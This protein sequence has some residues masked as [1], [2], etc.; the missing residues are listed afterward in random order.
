MK[1][2]VLQHLT[3]LG[4]ALNLLGVTL[5]GTSL[6][7]A[8]GYC[9]QVPRFAICDTGGHATPAECCGDWTGCELALQQLSEGDRSRPVVCVGADA[10]GCAIGEAVV[11]KRL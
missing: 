9:V 8:Q 7:F 2:L 3:R 6:T 10:I 4:W 11:C 1:E 5:A